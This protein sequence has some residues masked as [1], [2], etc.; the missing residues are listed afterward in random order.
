[1]HFD[2]TILW[3]A[4]HGALVFGDVVL[5]ADGGVRVCPE[6]WLEGATTRS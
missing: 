3:I 5:G 4:E 6:S 1:M 2:E